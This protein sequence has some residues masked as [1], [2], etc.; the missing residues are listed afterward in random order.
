MGWESP[1]EEKE[2]QACC[3]GCTQTPINGCAGCSNGYAGDRGGHPA[4]HA[5][6]GASCDII[7][8]H[9]HHFV[10]HCRHYGPHVLGTAADGANANSSAL[11]TAAGNAGTVS[12]RAQI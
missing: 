7:G 5:S 12:C 1:Q 6:C 8:A 3:Q 2:G 10:A 11:C 9:C 4:A